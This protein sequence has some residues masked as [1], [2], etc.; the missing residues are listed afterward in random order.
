MTTDVTTAN[1]AAIEPIPVLAPGQTM[2]GVTEQLSDL[3]LTRRT[4]RWWFGGLGL[5]FLLVLVFLLAITLLFARGVGIWGIQVPVAWGFAI[6]NFVWW[7][8]IGHAGTLIS[9]ILLLLRQEWRTSINRIAE[10]MTVFAVA[11]AALFPILH[12]GRPWLFYYLLPYPNTMNLPPQFRSPLVWDAFAVMTYA[13]V[14][15]VFWLVGMIPDLATLRDRA[16]NKWVRGF[17][18]ILALGWRGSAQ[19][20][21]RFHRAYY[22]VA[23]LVTALVV[24]V[25]TIVSFDFA[26]AVVPGW[27]N[28]VY[29]PY[30]V[31][32]AI[33]SGFAMVLVLIIPLRKLLH[34]ENMITL[35]HIDNAA[36]VML[37]SGLIV[38]YGYLFENFSGLY[39]GDRFDIQAIMSRFTGAFAILYWLQIAFNVL[40]P[41]LLWIRAVRHNRIVLFFISVGIL[42]GMW[43]ERYVLITT[44]L[45]RAYE[46]S[47]W[48]VFIPTIWD[49]AT[50]AGTVG[51]FFLMM[52]AFL[53]FLPSVANYEMRELI[54]K[55]EERKALR[56]RQNTGGDGRGPGTL[57]GSARGGGTMAGEEV[58]P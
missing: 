51:L 20:W 55:K 14:S 33:Y 27:H 30:F 57:T 48:G 38:A 6:T 3:V 58:T 26:V 43:M 42:F 41:Q 50:F 28:T 4:P 53:R 11:Q 19:H 47:K 24:S 40:I 17:Y 56:A 8:G 31:A 18:G 10:A 25:H 15:T 46:P 45:S 23:A 13:S 37:A 2:E 35:Q 9:A 44:N 12:L 1:P 34:I 49:I 39:S 54:V 7:I 21:R 5:A 22:L 52:F 36:K 32:G 29:P 16:T